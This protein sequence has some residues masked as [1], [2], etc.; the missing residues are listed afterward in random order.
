MKR[1]IIILIIALLPAQAY[2]FKAY[3]HSMNASVY[4]MPSMKSKKLVTLDKGAQLQVTK[5][6]GAWYK[7][8]TTTGKQT[9]GWIYKFM[10]RKKP[11]TNSSKLYSKLRSF[12]YKIESISK[13]SR[14]RP[15]SYT[16]TAAARG[17]REKR[18]H[19]AEKYNSDYDALE[20]IESIEI[21]DEEAIAFLKEGGKI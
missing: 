12:F 9:S 5:S 1:L 21:T 7:V 14:R 17:L 8:K 18:R 13:K 6:K 16:S 4:K 10:V 2:A 11:I 3:V 19:F 15:S 20:V